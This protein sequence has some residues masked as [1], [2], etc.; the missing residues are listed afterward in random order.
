[1]AVVTSEAELRELADKE[2]PYDGDPYDFV[3]IWVNEYAK[4][5]WCLRYAMLE[6]ICERFV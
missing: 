2:F 6:D 4:N 3:S 1:M 5:L